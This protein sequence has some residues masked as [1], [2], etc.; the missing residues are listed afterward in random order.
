[1]SSL[2]IKHEWDPENPACVR[3]GAAMRLRD[4]CEWDEFAAMNLCHECALSDIRGMRPAVTMKRHKTKAPGRVRSIA[5][6]GSLGR[7]VGR[8]LADARD[9]KR[10]MRQRLQ[11][12]RGDWVRQ[13][14]R[15]PLLPNG[16]PAPQWVFYR[17]AV[18]NHRAATRQLKALLRILPDGSPA[19]PEKNGGA[20]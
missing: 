11:D 1:M 14:V 7:L 16:R 6:P 4:G 20:R 5:P 13:P 19:T 8:L 3:C 15:G 18:R 9:R 10:R 2:K 12:L 17:N